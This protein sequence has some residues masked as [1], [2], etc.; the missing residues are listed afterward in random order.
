MNYAILET[1][2]NSNVDLVGKNCAYYIW[3]SDL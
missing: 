1:E 2:W 3:L